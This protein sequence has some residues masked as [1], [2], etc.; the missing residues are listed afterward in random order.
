MPKVSPAAHRQVEVRTSPGSRTRP[1]TS[2][3]SCNRADGENCTRLPTVWGGRLN[4]EAVAPGG[5]YQVSPRLPDG[6]GQPLAS[7]PCGEVGRGVTRA[8]RVGSDEAA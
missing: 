8:R 6:M 2:S 7:P 5:E 1:V 3:A 4:R